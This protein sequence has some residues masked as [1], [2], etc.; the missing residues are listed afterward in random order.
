MRK[1]KEINKLTVFDGDIIKYRDM[2]YVVGSGFISCVRFLRVKRINNNLTA[3]CVKSDG[4]IQHVNM[5]DSRV[6]CGY[7]TV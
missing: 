6:I 3:L 1:Y 5:I 4:K 2:R 7:T